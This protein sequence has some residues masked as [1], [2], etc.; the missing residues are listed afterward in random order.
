MD[1][2]VKPSDMAL[3]TYANYYTD[4]DAGWY[5]LRSPGDDFNC[6]CGVYDVGYVDCYDYYGDYDYGFCPAFVINL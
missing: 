1:R 5:F 4:T 6:V 2:K 3:A